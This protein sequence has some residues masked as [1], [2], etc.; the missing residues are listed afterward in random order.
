MTGRSPVL[1]LLR[2]DPTGR[3][4]GGIR[5]SFDSLQQLQEL[6]HPVRFVAAS[7]HPA[8]R[9]LDVDGLAGW[10][11]PHAPVRRR[12]RRGVP[13]QIAKRGVADELVDRLASAVTTELGDQPPVLLLEQFPMFEWFDRCRRCSPLRRG[14]CGNTTTNRRT[15]R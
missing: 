13:Y 15:R 7:D 1:A 3:R 2:S 10:S 9:R 14:Y 6:G 12:L 8:L 5:L 4:Y 11:V